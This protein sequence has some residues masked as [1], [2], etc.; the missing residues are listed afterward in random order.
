M[1]QITVI[2]QSFDEV[3]NEDSE[4]AITVW[5]TRASVEKEFSDEQLATQVYQSLTAKLK[6]D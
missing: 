4:T 5:N 3:L 2:M 1:M 6:G